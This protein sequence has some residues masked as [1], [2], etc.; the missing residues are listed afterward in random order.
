M[1]IQYCICDWDVI[2]GYFVGYIEYQK[3]NNVWVWLP[4]PQY[5]NFR[6][7]PISAM[8]GK[9][10]LL[11]ISPNK[12]LSFHGKIPKKMKAGMGQPSNFNGLMIGW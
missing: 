10:E 8:S 11:T 4:L 12:S 2:I 3:P 5:C 1:V 6:G 7:G 9:L